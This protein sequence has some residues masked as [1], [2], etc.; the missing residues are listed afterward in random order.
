MSIVGMFLAIGS[1]AKA[2]TDA[3]LQDAWVNAFPTNHSVPIFGTVEW[4]S[5]TFATNGNVTWKWQ[6]DGRSETTSGTYWLVAET[7]KPNLRP[8][9]KVIIHPKTIGVWRDITLAD[10][11]VDQDNRFP[12][13][14]MVLKWRDEAGNRMTFIRQEDDKTRR[15][16]PLP[17]P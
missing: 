14:W 13:S 17:V 5:L 3:E 15:T 10:V 7:D 6:R 2:T 12:V 16:T 9:F 1:Q 4:S 11:M 8:V